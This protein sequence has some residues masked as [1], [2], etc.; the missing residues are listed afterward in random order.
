MR[1]WNYLALALAGCLPP[2]GEP[3]V[4]YPWHDYDADGYSEN[5]GDCNDDDSSIAPD[6]PEACDGVDNDCDGV[7]DPPDSVWYADGDQDGYGDEGSAT[8]ACDAPQDHVAVAGDCDDGDGSINPGAAELC[9]GVDDDCNGLDD[10]DPSDEQ[11]WY[12]DNDF[13]GFGDRGAATFEGCD[14][15]K[16]WADNADDCDDSDPA[17]NPEAEEVPCNGI[18]DDCLAE[19]EDGTDKDGDGFAQCAG[20]CD[21]GDPKV[22]PVTPDKCDGIDRDCD[23]AWIVSVPTVCS[24]IPLATTTAPDAIPSRIEVRAGLY[25]GPIGFQGKPIHLL[26]IDGPDNTTLQG[27]GDDTVVRFDMGEDEDAILEGFTITAGIGAGAKGEK[28]GGGVYVANSTATL[29]GVRIEGNRAHHGGGVY[30]DN[31]FLYIANSWLH[32]NLALD[33][34]GGIGATNSLV[35]I[36]HTRMILNEAVNGAGMAGDNVTFLLENAVIA[37]N[38]GV[39]I[40]VS[41]GSAELYNVSIHNNGSDGLRI[42]KSALVDLTNVA[43]SGHTAAA[44]IATDSTAPSLAYCNLWEDGVIGWTD[45]TGSFGNIRVDPL[46]VDVNTSPILWDF[47]LQPKS[48]MIDAGKPKPPDPDGSPADI[49]AWGGPYADQW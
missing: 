35:D 23:G 17:R 13:D 40:F 19:T 29:I 24:D 11:L 37:A 43:I 45:P 12:A 6:Q 33:E 27:T 46:Y 21:D 26:A 49:G 42:H 22:N 2:L 14:P 30:V 38:N 48:L 9:N 15:G 20:D 1:S 47:T 10:D 36:R 8:E 16:G 34:G 4:D 7:T 28:Q 3:T 18:D 5:D 32:Q 25:F 39:G 41:Q 31:G 44:G